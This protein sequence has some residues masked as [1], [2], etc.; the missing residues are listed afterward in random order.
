MAVPQ[1]QLVTLG[2]GITSAMQNFRQA[3]QTANDLLNQYDN[4]DAGTGFQGLST[5][6]VSADG[7]LG[8]ADAAPVPANVIDTRIVSH[9]SVS[10]S[11]YN[12]G[13]CKDILQA[14]VDLM[15][16]VAVATQT[17]APAMLAKTSQ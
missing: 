2:N 13:V 15:N 16:G 4:L 14:F 1:D 9:L 11:S 10:I 7:S 6:E 8:S 17:Y 3:L 12:L 5:C